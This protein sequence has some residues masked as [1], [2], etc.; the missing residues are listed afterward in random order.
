MQPQNSVEIYKEKITITANRKEV[1]AAPF[2]SPFRTCTQ[3]TRKWAVSIITYS[4]LHILE[5]SFLNSS[6]PAGTTD[7][8]YHGNQTQKQPVSHYHHPYQQLTFILRY[9]KTIIAF[10]F[11]STITGFY[12][13][14][15]SQPTPCTLCC[16]TSFLHCT[17]YKLVVISDLC[18]VCV[19]PAEHCNK[20][21]CI[22]YVIQY[23]VC[24]RSSYMYIIYLPG[25]TLCTL[26]TPYNMAH[27]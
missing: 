1:W 27:V 13:S 8:P 20:F 25:F 12:P 24:N 19:N 9:S 7:L 18:E 23:S 17:S 4:S 2:S 22:H 3:K 10:C 11:K 6:T 16:F 15:T 26:I 5:T 14:S 21:V